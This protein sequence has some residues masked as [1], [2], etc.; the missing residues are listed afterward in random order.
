MNQKQLAGQILKGH[1]AVVTGASSGIGK[2][3]AR[4]LAQLGAD[5]VIAARRLDRLEELAKDLRSA[6]EIEVQC[7]QVDLCDSGAPKVLFDA[8]TQGGKVVTILVNNAGLARFGAF[9]GFP[10]NDHHATLQVNAAAPTQMTYLFV[11]HMLEH[12][13]KSYITQVASISAFQPVANFAVYSG[14]KGYLLSF[15]ESL[16][17]EL[18]DSNIGILCLC[19]GGTYTEFFEF[20]GQK[21]TKKGHRVM[22]SAE[23]VVR[24]GIAA[25]LKNE[26]VFVPGFLNKL[27]CFFPRFLPRGLRQTLAFKTMSQ[28]VEQVPPKIGLSNTP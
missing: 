21:M 3:Y 1:R 10:Y 24:Q 20:S 22:M 16:A 11:K 18:R 2:E 26:V 9:M 8:A 6:H 17:Y 25:M 19:P 23:E 28:S 5:L 27:A 15:S 12:K 4:Q 14:T 7:V 13:Q